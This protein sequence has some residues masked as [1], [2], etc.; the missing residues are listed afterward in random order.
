M[1]LVGSG[2]LAGVLQKGACVV[3]GEYVLSPK[4]LQT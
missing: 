3:S 1:G 2:S 4:A